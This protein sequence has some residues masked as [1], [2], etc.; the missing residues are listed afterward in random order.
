MWKKS[1][2][3]TAAAVSARVTIPK[4]EYFE[5]RTA[6]RD[7]E[8]LELEAMKAAQEFGQR[9]TAAKERA[10]ALFGQSAAAHGLSTGSYLW[11]DTTCEII[12]V[13][14]PVKH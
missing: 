8:A 7:V 3:Q 4:A 14:E 11:D 1:H 9:M 2:A 12:A 13:V 5:L 10:A 6:L